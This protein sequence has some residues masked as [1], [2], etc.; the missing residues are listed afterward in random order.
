[1]QH[2]SIIE[3]Y[4]RSRSFQVAGVDILD[5]Q[6][7]LCLDLVK[8]L[9]LFDPSRS[10]HAKPCTG[11]EQKG[12]SSWIKSRAM[13]V[14]LQHLRIRTR[15]INIEE[16]SRVEER[17]TPTCHLVSM[18]ERHYDAV[19]GVDELRQLATKTQIAAM[20]TVLDDWTTDEITENLGITRAA[21]NWRLRKLRDRA[22]ES[23]HE[24][25][26]N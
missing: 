11:C 5:F 19:K 12:C 22:M 20:Q 25:H 24:H 6:Q 26:A 16:R 13:L 21:R 10:P 17:S 1:M 9:H 18:F 7:D 15:H 2:A 23:K 3:R 8:A 14:R 4:S